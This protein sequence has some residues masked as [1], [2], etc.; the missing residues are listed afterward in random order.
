MATSDR[1]LD[2][3]DQLA[4]EIH[5]ADER[6]LKLVRKLKRQFYLVHLHY[7]NQAC[8]QRYR[9]L[10]AWAYQVLFVNR[11]IGVPDSTRA[12]PT[13]PNALDAPDYPT[14]EKL[15]GARGDAL[16][17]LRSFRWHVAMATG[18]CAYQRSQRAQAGGGVSN[19]SS[20][21]MSEVGV[22]APTVMRDSSIDSASPS[23][24]AEV[25]SGR[26]YTH[27]VH[28]ARHR[29]EVKSVDARQPRCPTALYVPHG[30]AMSLARLTSA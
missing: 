12:A 20:N 10:P 25:A 27:A 8:S 29:F 1:V 11:R 2:R 19:C 22:P 15:P 18:A 4:M 21:Q 6:F 28:V 24:S 7:N 26:R 17:R 5:G 30:P 3:M 16:E 23:T 9:P 14:R 13:L